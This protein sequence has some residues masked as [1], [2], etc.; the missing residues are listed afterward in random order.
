M[1]N[2]LRLAIVTTLALG[3]SLG[4]STVRYTTIESLPVSITSIN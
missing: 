3:F 4:T 1:R 2:A